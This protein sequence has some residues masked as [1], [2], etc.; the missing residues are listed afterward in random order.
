MRKCAR[1][2]PRSVRACLSSTAHAV[3]G[4]EGLTLST[5]RKGL[6][7]LIKITTS[8][9][10]NGN[11][12]RGWLT[13]RNGGAI[14]GWIEEGYRGRGAIDGYDD[15]ELGAEIK[16]TPR[17]FQRLRKLGEEAGKRNREVSGF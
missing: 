10:T 4:R 7:M 12:R 8:N 1:Q 2:F 15:A 17:E 13:T 9:D 16:V 11:P 14:L 5:N 6:E 3:G